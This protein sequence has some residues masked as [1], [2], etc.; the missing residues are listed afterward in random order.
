MIANWLIAA[1]L[2]TIAAHLVSHPA[3][4]EHIAAKGQ[5]NPAAALH[6][7]FRDRLAD[8]QPCHACPEMVRIPAGDFTMGSP[9]E[10]EDR[11]ENEGPQHAVNIARPFAIGKFEVTFAEWDACVAAGGCGH[12][13]NDRG[14]GRD[15]LPVAGVSWNDITSDYLPWLT[16]VTGK[17]YRLPTEA[18]W[19]YAARAGTTTPFWWGTSISTDRA[20]YNGDFRYAS[21]LKGENRQKAVSV[22]RFSAN[23]WGLYNV[24]GNVWEWVQDCY[25]PSYTGAPA[26]GSAWITEHCRMRVSR[27]GSWGNTPR[28]LRSAVRVALSPSGRSPQAGFRVART[29][30]D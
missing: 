26:D 7:S 20:N 19:E 9:P 16:R 2:A 12:S 5:R 18:E 11:D 15:N 8:G 3:L 30:S 6:H 10:E 4:A 14:S 21:G 24:H 27:G 17:A 1:A 29:L 22:E 28:Y 13:P 23:P 25:N